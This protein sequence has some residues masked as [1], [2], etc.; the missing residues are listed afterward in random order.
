VQRIAVVGAAGVGKSTLAR[1]LSDALGIPRLEIDAIFHQPGWTQLDPPEFRERV[2]T[3]TSRD[4]WIVDGNYRTSIGDLVWERAD[5]IIWLDYSRSVVLGRVTRRTFRRA[6]SREELWNGNRESLRDA[7]SLDPA[8]SVIRWS[9]TQ[10]AKYQVEYAEAIA[11]QPRAD[12]A[13]VRLRTPTETSG[14]LANVVA[15]QSS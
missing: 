10:H 1:S 4:S 8:R 5:T 15:A 9:W 12:L 2:D 3:F 7:L 11:N 13:T 14:W 6:L